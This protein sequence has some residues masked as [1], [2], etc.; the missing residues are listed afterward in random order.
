MTFGNTTKK[1]VIRN[2][3]RNK[4][5]REIKV[6]LSFHWSSAVATV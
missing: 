5:S 4:M 6:S 1:H 3:I 2:D